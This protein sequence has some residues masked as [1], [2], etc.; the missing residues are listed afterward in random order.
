LGDGYPYS[1]KNWGPAKNTVSFWIPIIG[2]SSDKV[3]SFLPGSHLQDYEKYLPRDSKHMAGEYRIK[4][5]ISE[6]EV[7]RPNLSKGSTIIFNPDTIHSE[8]IPAGS[9]TRFSIEFRILPK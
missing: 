5:S 2:F 8:E 3:I 4:R 7:V 1:R 9:I 6:N